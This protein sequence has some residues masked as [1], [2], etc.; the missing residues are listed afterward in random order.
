VIF[1]KRRVEQVGPGPPVG[2]YWDGRGWKDWERERAEA[3]A[4]ATFERHARLRQEQ[5]VA[6]VAKAGPPPSDRRPSN[7]P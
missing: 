6:E 4:A 5:R 2:L 1:R 3:T 7:L